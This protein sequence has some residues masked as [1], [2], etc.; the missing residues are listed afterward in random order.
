MIETPFFFRNG[1]YNL[2][3][4]LHH[5]TDE[6]K[7]NSKTGIVFCDP[8]GEEKLWAHRVMVNFAR[9][10][11]RNSFWAFRFDCMGHGDS[12]GNF[13]DSTI[14]TRVSD[15]HRA[16]EVLKEKTNVKQIGLL[17]LRLG[18]TLG[19]LA[20]KRNRT[21]DILILWNPVISGNSYIQECLRSNLAM[22]MSTYRRI[23]HTRE[24]LISELI[25]GK[26][27]NIDGYLISADLYQQL[28]GID[29]LNQQENCAKRVF[30]VQIQKS[31]Q[32]ER[33]L[34]DLDRL[35]LRIREYAEEVKKV[36]VCEDSFW[37]E[38]KAYYQRADTLF[39]V[40]L[41]WLNHL[42]R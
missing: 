8:F 3:G 39:G 31:E 5:P 32:A 2:F 29:L 28:S 17:G 33:A 26:L 25:S 15:I 18:G 30:I 1:D 22:Q 40:T 37:R 36:K 10:L 23:L 6:S 16:V 38:L 13:E 4:V 21:I 11:A 41:E 9:D 19:M 27:V 7:T 12:D 24:Q 35:C 14:E 20:S 34:D 42:A